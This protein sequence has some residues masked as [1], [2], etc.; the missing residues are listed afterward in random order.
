MNSPDLQGGVLPRVGSGE[1]NPLPLTAK[2]AGR[3]ETT[4][5]AALRLLM[6]MVG[7]A[8]LAADRSLFWTILGS[9]AKNSQ[10]PDKGRPA[11]ATQPSGKLESSPASN[12]EPHA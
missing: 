10:A 5:Q 3:D 1:G 11:P 9:Y 2:G 4:A 8:G 7:S 6:M 12:Q